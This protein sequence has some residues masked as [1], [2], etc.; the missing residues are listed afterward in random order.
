MNVQRTLAAAAAAVLVASCSSSPTAPNVVSVT[1]SPTSAT[2]E[3][4]GTQQFTAVAKD[5]NGNAVSDSVIWTSSDASV[6]SV[7]TSG[8][9]TGVA[10]GNAAITATVGGVAGSAVITVNTPQQPCSDVKTVD[11]ALGETQA[12]ALADCLLLPSGASGDRYRVTVTRPTQT[13]NASDVP[14][15][16]L[17]VTGI[18]VSQA[19]AP[20]SAQRATVA[21]WSPIPGLSDASFLKAVEISRATSR[22]HTELRRREREMIQRIGAENVLAPR[23]TLALQAP[24]QATSPATR[25]FNVSTTC[26]YT[27][28]D[29]VTTAKLI[30]ENND[31]AI[32]QDSTEQATS[33]ISVTL[34][35]KMADY[36]SNYARDMV[37]SYFGTPSD[38]DG[39]GKVVLLATPAVTG[40]TAAFVWSGDFFPKTACP[41]SNQME[42]MYFS[43]DLI[44]AMDASSPS[45]QALS[46]VAHEM[47]HV[48]SLY[49]RIESP[50]SGYHPDWIEEGRAEISG[51]MSSRL[52]WAANGGPAVN[53]VVSRSSFQGN[54]IDESNYG[55]A[56]TLARTVWYLST[57]PNALVTVPDG[58]PDTYSIYGG[59]WLFERWLGDAY[60]NAASAPEADAPLF[61]TLTDSLT[62]SGTA[63]LQSETGKSYN[64][65]FQEFV[66]AIVL[67][68]TGAPEPNLGFSTY[69]FVSAAEIFCTPNP[70][71]VFPWPVTTTGT[72]GDCSTNPPTQESSV[73]T[74]SFATKNYVGPIGASGIRVHD[75]VSNGTGTGAQ[76]RVDMP[77]PGQ[78]LVSRLR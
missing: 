38:I 54:G 50:Y 78:I 68:Q 18:G 17:S 72:A 1:V 8:M 24:A 13:E 41:A 19:P 60:G 56:L 14:N 15:V 12:Y 46:T 11:L 48:V 23:P 66:T 58:T 21:P 22:F 47:E 61:K 44:T 20:V 75:F 35:K 69:D 10:A 39:N 53:A 67:H 43:T 6:V 31:L 62:V 70:V 3:V 34:A 2:V 25:T 55:V 49:H 65:L 7:S 5:E 71:G 42:L 9:A 36:Y 28:A 33:P 52:A 40:N 16:T 26:S 32:Y 37:A 63:G 76:I 59:G 64:Q 4:G 30:Y 45:Y 51:E 27:Q 57:Q 77:A 73:A 74:A 29:S